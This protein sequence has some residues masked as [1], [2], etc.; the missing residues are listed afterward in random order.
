MPWNRPGID[1]GSEATGLALEAQVSPIT[2]GDI[3]QRTGEYP[4]SG[5]EVCWFSDP[6]V[7]WL[8]EVP[9]AR[10]DQFQ[11]PAHQGSDA[12]VVEG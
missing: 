2:G 5:V 1:G 3:V 4:A 11:A 6:A 10:V 7:S 8:G 9:S 12:R